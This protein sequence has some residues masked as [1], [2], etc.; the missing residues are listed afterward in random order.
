[1]STGHRSGPKRSTLS[2]FFAVTIDL[3]ILGS[4]TDLAARLAT[5]D[6]GKR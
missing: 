1:M 4:D 5:A 2:A 6:H 3:N